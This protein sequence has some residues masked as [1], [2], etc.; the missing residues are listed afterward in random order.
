L[1]GRGVLF[2]DDGNGRQQGLVR[3]GKGLVLLLFSNV[4][5]VY[6]LVVSSFVWEGKFGE[7]N[8]YASFFLETLTSRELREAGS[9]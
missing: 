8:G 5:S 7:S 1:R 4:F 6:F 9:R 2:G 3:K